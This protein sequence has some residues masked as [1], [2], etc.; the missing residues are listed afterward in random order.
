MQ[1]L[2]KFYFLFEYYFFIGENCIHIA[3]QRNQSKILKMLIDEGADINARVCT[4][5]N[6][7]SI[8]LRDNINQLYINGNYYFIDVPFN[9]YYFIRK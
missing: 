8:F 7:E 1:N 5:Y 9:A 6:N 3:A 2:L 4:E